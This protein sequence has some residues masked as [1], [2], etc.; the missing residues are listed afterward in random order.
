LIQIKKTGL[1]KQVDIVSE[2]L[3]TSVAIMVR[4]NH[5]GGRTWLSFFATKCFFLHLQSWP[6]LIL[7]SGVLLSL[8]TRRLQWSFLLNDA[9]T[10]SKSGASTKRC[11]H[12]ACC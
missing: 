1:K 10:D 9:I 8:R 5:T 12:H 11:N 7:F 2:V 4:R 6:T 3:L